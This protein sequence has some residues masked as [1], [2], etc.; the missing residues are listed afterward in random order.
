MTAELSQSARFN[1]GGFGLGIQ[2][3]QRAWFDSSTGNEG[4]DL[5]LL[6]SN[7]SPELV[8][9]DRAFINEFVES[10]QRD[11]ESR[12]GFASAQPSNFGLTHNHTLPPDYWSSITGFHGFPTLSALAAPGKTSAAS[13]AA[14]TKREHR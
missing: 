2:V 12:S 10:A 14:S 13:L 11:T 4:V 5:V 9:R 3:L 7:D 8:R 6:Q 1:V